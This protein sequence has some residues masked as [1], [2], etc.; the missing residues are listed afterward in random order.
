MKTSEQSSLGF[1]FLHAIFVGKNCEL[2]LSFCDFPLT[3][4]LQD[5]VYQI[6][7][8]DKFNEIFSDLIQK[9]PEQFELVSEQFLFKSEAM[10]ALFIEAEFPCSNFSVT[11]HFVIGNNKIR[12]VHFLAKALENA[13][14][15]KF[16]F[17]NEETDRGE[18]NSSDFFKNSPITA[19][20]NKA[21]LSL[22]KPAVDTSFECTDTSSN[23]KLIDKVSNLRLRSLNFLLKHD[24]LSKI[25]KSIPC[26]PNQ[27]QLKLLK[28][29]TALEHS[30]I[31]YWEYD[32]VKDEG[33]IDIFNNKE[34]IRYSGFT[35]MLGRFFNITPRSQQKL[36]D[37]HKA[38]LKGETEISA[39]IQVY[40]KEGKE[41]WQKIR[42]SA[43][44]TDD[45]VLAIGTCENNNDLIELKKLFSVAT[46]QT[47]LYILNYDFAART[48]TLENHP[49]SNF[50]RTT[51][52]IN[53]PDSL[54]KAELIHPDDIEKCK[55]IF[56][57]IE[58]G[59]AVIKEELRIKDSIMDEFVWHQISFTVKPNK[60]GSPSSAIGTI[61]NIQQQKNLEENY[62]QEFKLFDTKNEANILNCIYSFNEKKVIRMISSI[63]SLNHENL[64][65]QELRND[66]ADLCLDQEKKQL[67]LKTI[68]RKKLL[69]FI[70]EQNPQEAII[71]PFKTNGSD[72]I[73]TSLKI[74]LL[75]NPSTQENFAKIT[76]ED[77]TI[78]YI[79]KAYSDKLSNHRYDFIMRVNY[80]TGNYVYSLGS[81]IQ[82]SFQD[83]SFSGNYFYDYLSFGNAIVI[84]EERSTYLE[85]VK[86]QNILERLRLEGE[87]SFI[88][89][90]VTK[91]N[92][93]R[94]NR[95]H[96][97]MLDENSQTFCERS[98]DITDNFKLE[99]EKDSMLH[100]SLQMA[101]EAIKAKS[102]FM[103]S[104]SHDI[105]TPMNAIIGMAN[106]A[107]E[108]IDNKEQIK[109]SLDVILSSSENLLAIINDILDVNRMES[110]KANLSNEPFDLLKACAE[111]ANTFKGIVMQKKQE[112][113]FECNSVTNDSIIGDISNFKRILTNLLGN[114]VKFT[115][116]HGT[117]FFKVFQE[118]TN[119]PKTA[120]FKIQI[121]DT[122]IGISKEQMPKIFEAF[123]REENDTIKSIEGSGL[124]LAIVKALVEMQG[125]T[126]CAESE[127]G[128]GTTFTLHL[129][130]AVAEQ[131][132]KH[133]EHAAVNFNTIDLSKKHILLVEDHPVNS[134]VATKCLEKMGATVITAENGEVAVNKFLK[135]KKNEIDFIFMDVQMPVLN[136]YQAT[137]AIRHSNHTRAKTIPIIAMTA[138][139]FHEDVQ[140][141][142]DA[143]MNAHIAKPISLEDISNTLK[144]LAIIK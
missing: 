83:I 15:M 104:M 137:K 60:L 84:K 78:N 5:T 113:K 123:Q 51:S 36:I 117:V 62:K 59:E 143:G 9:K 126:V 12:S 110:G 136:G 134:L 17:S 35:E 124:G 80:A 42:Y 8:S 24:D 3:V 102:Q 46:E 114:A 91:D 54:F 111:I 43:I 4:I 29:K 131:K 81:E 71:F 23:H 138:N 93:I 130:Y 2:A 95:A 48:L 13:S 27:I 20:K 90:T 19:L 30:G 122:G 38:L 98:F 53:V 44:K 28:L 92:E 141:S 135:S 73:W 133:E 85:T 61:Y 107:M 96:F 16:L 58:S 26:S 39:D 32:P 75:K 63:E 82:K 105:R 76:M 64:S 69:K 142:L 10:S 86:P 7:V 45:S 66:I 21:M 65:L 33:N 89:R 77:I 144:K 70:G 22:L 47:G 6:S 68:S 125:G 40:N 11:I 100:K 74:A 50:F 121:Q 1:Q 128:K 101:N 56:K 127:K 55:D 129:E 108:D 31:F 41:E 118:E 52:F 112:F 94:Y 132:T 139:A 109:E 72:S 103:A 97:F 14:K 116:M 99:Q 57:K 88:Y 140:K 87:F 37:L 79:K 18:I 34:E 120:H 25:K 49:K 106:I 67:I 119:N 115:P